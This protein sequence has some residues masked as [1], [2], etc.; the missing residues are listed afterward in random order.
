MGGLKSPHF[1]KPILY[2]SYM[3][4]RPYQ[5]PRRQ[6]KINDMIY[7]PGSRQGGNVWIGGIMMNVPQPSSG[8]AVSPTPTPSVTPTMTVTPTITPTITPT[9]TVTPSITP[10]NTP[11][12]SSSPLPAGFAEAT[13]YLNKV[14]T[15]G[16]TLSST[17]SAATYTMFNSLF[18]NNLW[19]KIFAFYPHIGGVSAAHGVNGKSPNANSITFNGGWTFTNGGGSDPNG[20]NGYGVL[21]GCAPS[22]YS[23]QNDGSLG[24]YCLTND[25]TANDIDMDSY[26]TSSNSETLMMA[27]LDGTYS[28]YTKVNAATPVRGANLIS[29]T[30]GMFIASR[31]E[32]TKQYTYYNGVFAVSGTSNS[33]TPST[34]DMFIATGNDNGVPFSAYSTRAHG[35]SFVGSGLT[36]SEVSTLSTII[37]NF[38]TSLSRNTY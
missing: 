10:T 34:F 23:T 14:V 21:N 22:V 33:L 30:R 36:A 3:K 12:P 8:P 32:S 1:H 9:N 4:L 27:Y 35:F 13:T 29:D 7:P 2:L 31:T 17:I 19:N 11:T 24:F 26:T 28:P 20:T 25:T 37:N 6:P 5:A 15:T 16:G 18:T 38:Q